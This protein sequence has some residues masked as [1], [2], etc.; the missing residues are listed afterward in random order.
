MKESKAKQQDLYLNSALE[1][2][3]FDTHMRGKKMVEHDF[4]EAA[5][6]KLALLK[7]YQLKQA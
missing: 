3:D 7:K 6:A 4:I 1:T 2:L 5:N